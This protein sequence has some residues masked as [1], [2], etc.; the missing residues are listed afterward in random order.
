MKNG[1]VTRTSLFTIKSAH[2]THRSNVRVSIVVS[3]KITKSAVARNRIRR[4]L[5]ELCR[6]TLDMSS[7]YDIVCI[8]N[9]PEVGLMDAAVLKQEF[10]AVLQDVSVK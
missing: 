10:K 9:T 6:T 8:V 1:K 2:N 5:Y 4:R 7:G 3:K